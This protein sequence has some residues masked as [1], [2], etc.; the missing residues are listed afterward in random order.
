MRGS[1][2]VACWL[3]LA[4]PVTAQTQPETADQETTRRLLE[5]VD[6]LERQVRVLRQ[7]AEPTCAYDLGDEQHSQRHETNGRSCLERGRNG[8]VPDR[9]PRCNDHHHEHQGNLK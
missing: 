7:A 2:L 1:V 5:R 3:M 4:W 9:P 6:E 8:V